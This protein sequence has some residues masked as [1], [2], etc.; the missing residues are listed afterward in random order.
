[1]GIELTEGVLSD[2][3]AQ[4]INDAAESDEGFYREYC[5][6]IALFEAA[7]LSIQH[8]SAMSV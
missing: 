7:R 6:W 3:E 1:M 2:A 4:R 5:V 8:R